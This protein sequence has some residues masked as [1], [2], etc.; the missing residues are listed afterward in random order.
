MIKSPFIILTV[1]VFAIFGC[2]SDT[3]ID[4]GDHSTLKVMSAPESGIT[5][6]NKLKNSEQLNIIKYLYYYNGG[7]VAVGDLNQ[8]GLEDIYF[9]GNESSDKLYFNE[10]DLKFEDVTTSAGII[11]DQSWSSGVTIEDINGD[12]LN[13]IYVSKVGVLTNQNIHNQLYINQGGGKFL[14]QSKQFGLD[15]RGFGTQACFLDYDKDGDLDVYLLNHAIH[16]V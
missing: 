13:D 11:E 1:F 6:N 3:V 2:K 5:F 4:T 7:G 16:S 10:G 14:E 8:D 12:G 15:F 9:T